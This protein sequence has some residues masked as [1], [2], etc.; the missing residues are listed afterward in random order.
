MGEKF[1]KLLQCNAVLIAAAMA[2]QVFAGVASA[3]T[4]L[5]VQ[6]ANR[7]EIPLAEVM[8]RVPPGYT[9][10]QIDYPHGLWPWT[11]LF[12]ATGAV[13]IEAGVSALDVAIR[14]TLAT[15][16][17]QVLVIGESLGS[18]VVDQELRNLATEPKLDRL[19]F[20]A[21]A[22]PGRPGGLISYIPY[23][24]P[25]ALT[26]FTISQPVPVTPYEVKVIKLDYDGISS[27]PDRPWHLLAGLNAM[28]GGFV[29][30]GTDHYGNAAQEIINGT[31]PARDITV[32]VN[33]MGGITT[34]YAAEQNPALTHLLEPILPQSVAFLNKYLTPIINLGYS[35]F[36]PDAGP[37]LAPGGALV[38]KNGD[39]VCGRKALGSGDASRRA[40]AATRVSARESRRAAPR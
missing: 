33:S 30:H 25:V 5:W 29:Y 3:N 19:S 40:V 20:E 6:G 26:L 36:T 8:K 4:V 10:Q 18:L 9:L 12:S 17:G 14:E 28:V 24:L 27:W 11:G 7:G 38:N 22:D 37:H 2:A 31:F 1:R 35:Q 13:S 21:I 15:D 39:P 32:E 16:P 34:T 23:G